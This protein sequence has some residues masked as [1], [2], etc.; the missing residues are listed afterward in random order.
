MLKDLVNI[1]NDY[2]TRV[3]TGVATEEDVE[4]L[5]DVSLILQSKGYPI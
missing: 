1:Y 3:Y 5:Q 2:K 4:L